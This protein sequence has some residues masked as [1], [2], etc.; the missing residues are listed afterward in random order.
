MKKFL[1][2]MMLTVAFSA[3]ATTI[4]VMDS[5]TDT[6]HVDFQGKI[7]SNPG[8]IAD[9]GRDDDK[10]GY[11]DDV[12]GWNFAEGNNM[13]ID[14]SYLGTFSE[15]PYKFFDV[16]GKYFLGQ[17]TPEEIQWMKDSVKN[18]DFIK[19]L[20]KFGNFVHGTHVAGITQRNNPDAR[21]LAIKL[22]PTEVKLPGQSKELQFV[23]KDLRK[24]ALEKALAKLAD[25]QMKMLGEVFWYAGHH[26]ADVANGSFGT[27]FDQIKAI[28]DKI[29]SVIYF[30]KPTKEQS[31]A[32]ARS[33]MEKMLTLGA[34][35]VAQSPNTL[36]VFAAG[37]SGMNND[38]YPTSPTNIIA[39][40]VISVAATYEYNYL[41][42]F[43]N[44]GEKMVDVAAPGMLIRSEIPGN[45][46]LK[47]SGTSQASP[48]VAN[49]AAQIKDT[50][51]NLT[52]VQIKKIIMGTVDAKGFLKGKVKASGI[53]NPNRA[54]FAA[55]KSLNMDLDDAIDAARVNIA[56]IA[57]S[58]EKLMVNPEL[59]RPIPLP[60]TFK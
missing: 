49:I 40:N 26:K 48:Y 8:E 30:K 57:V 4:A 5:G 50:N 18:P 39:D 34:K 19:E 20:Q 3:Q 51:K 23:S 14:R 21:I 43:S 10:D 54:A 25:L 28:T 12:V 27:G 46:Y 53:V 52:P 44:Y 58:K 31:D 42:P 7:W 2:G 1:V 59:I 13:V 37:N 33:F 6:E 55:Q 32:T 41:A 29:Y 15:N 36:F 56:D 35:A 16:Q 17:A 24:K 11:P 45:E 22:I 38:L 47:V 9:N 60:S